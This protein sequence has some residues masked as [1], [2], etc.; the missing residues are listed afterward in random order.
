MPAGQSHL[1]KQLLDLSDTQD[2]ETARGQWKF[3]DCCW[4]DTK[5]KC[6]CGHVIKERCVLKNE[7]TSRLV[8]VGNCCVKHFLGDLPN[9]IATDACFAS[10]KRVKKDIRKT[11]HRDIVRLAEQRCVI[12]ARAAQWYIKW[13]RTRKLFGDDAI[14]RK[15]LNQVM[16][17]N[18]PYPFESPT[19]LFAHNHCTWN[20]DIH[21]LDLA[22]QKGSISAQERDWYIGNQWH[23]DI[24][25]EEGPYKVAIEERVIRAWFPEAAC[26]HITTNPPGPLPQRKTRARSAFIRAKG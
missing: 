17:T 16:L 25:D 20:L 1:R 22:V 3:Y 6:L 15:K 13:L 9:T 14:H 19:E 21:A 12:T 10:I 11:L 26:K 5:G 8:I 18:G 7:R 24:T 2:W 23:S 4:D